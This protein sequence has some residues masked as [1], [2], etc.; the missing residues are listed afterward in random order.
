LRDSIRLR[1]YG[2]YYCVYL[3]LIGN[4]SHRCCGL[5]NNGSIK[6]SRCIS[7]GVVVAALPARGVMRG[8]AEIGDEKRN[9]RA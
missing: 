8:A 2:N 6:S 4:E 1:I 9:G 7:S 5:S 3:C